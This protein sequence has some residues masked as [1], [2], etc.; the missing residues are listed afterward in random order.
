M[1]QGQLYIDAERRV[2]TSAIFSLNITDQA[3]ASRMF[4][5]RKPANV[6]VIPTDISYRV[7][8]REK[9]GRWYYSY[10]NAR[11]EFKV[12]WDRKLFNSVY[13]LD[14]EM[15]ITDWEL[16]PEGN[17]PRIRDRVRSSI[18]LSEAAEGFSDPD[19]WGEYNII[20]PDKSIES[21]I[22]KIQRQLRRT[23]RATDRTP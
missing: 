19:F 1:Y 14:L 15:A 23:E 9:D 17:V 13:S 8:Y 2:L 6:D 21:A 12:D 7:D 22:R 11:L 5:R 3:A 20:E 18:I 4:V 16:N 10:S